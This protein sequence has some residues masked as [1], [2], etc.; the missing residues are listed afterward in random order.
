MANEIKDGSVVSSGQH[1]PD[2]RFLL[3][4][5]GLLAVGAAGAAPAQ[6]GRAGSTPDREIIDRAAIDQIIQRERHARDAGLW[7]EML[8]C[9][10]PEAEIDVSWYHGDAAGFVARTRAGVRP[11]NLNFHEM[12]PAVV[13]VRE[14]R[15]VADTGCALQA[16]MQVDGCDVNQIGHVRLLWRARRLG[17]RWL[18]DGLRAIYVRDL[19][20]PCDPGR[21]P[22]LDAARLAGYRPS[23]RYLSYLLAAMGVPVNNA[24]PGVD[25]PETVV[26]LRD[27]ENRW[28]AAG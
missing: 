6:R 26:A 5:A 22:K 1:V 24:L 3:A 21:V 2:R 20:I 4:G 8:A 16:F 23:Y 14:D 27:A 25:R 18:I 17:G 28:L 7:D 15:A 10:H 9:Y 13:S 11:G 19:L 12:S